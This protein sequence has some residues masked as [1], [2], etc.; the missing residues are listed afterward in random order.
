M[1][2]NELEYY[3]RKYGLIA[4]I[5]ISLLIFLLPLF[6]RIMHGAPITPGAQSYQYLRQADLF[7]KGILTDPLHGTFI[8]PNPY[9]MLLALM[10]VFGAPW[11][12]PL[13][14]SILLMV[15]LYYYLM[16]L[17]ASRMLVVL[18]V[19]LLVLSPTMS[20][21]A[22]HHAP[23]LLAMV[24]IA[25]ALLLF[26]E[27]TTLACFAV[28]LAIITAPV[29]GIIAAAALMVAFFLQRKPDALIGT[30]IALAIGIV[31]FFLWSGHAPEI[32]EIASPKFSTGIFFELG[33]AGGISIFLVILAVYGIIVLGKGVRV[34]L[35]TALS[36]MAAF[37]FPSLIPVAVVALS[38]LA[39]RGIYN[40]MTT[41]WDLDLLQSALLVL[42]SCIMLFTLITTMRA[43]TAES[44][45]ADFAHVMVLLRNQYHEGAVL[46]APSY[47][48][49][50]EY[51][52]G[53][54]AV[55]DQNSPPAQ[56]DAFLYSR[57]S[58]VVYPA[59][60]ESGTAYI[61]ITGEM[62]GSTFTRS[63]EGILFLLHNTERF[64]KVEQTPG[65][66]LWY[67]IRTK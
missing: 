51:F 27:Y 31:W 10:Q 28:G 44:P 1:N 39:A 58:D 38:M 63:D 34:A 59:L 23:L 60:T 22:T 66:T 18:A 7:S 3:A 32:G 15:L 6:L 41:K 67:F 36:F 64:V 11:L 46:T 9:V 5:S 17:T 19:A 2:S 48:P 56:V 24:L 57:S 52:S 53:R 14:L 30:A 26:P 25:A 21:L 16:R 12:L 29:L 54:R 55:V 42:I 50:V 47:A 4:I 62:R 40:L 37:F 65:I 45:D 13:L 61:I 33:N 43:R 20:V 8:V 35:V 49:M